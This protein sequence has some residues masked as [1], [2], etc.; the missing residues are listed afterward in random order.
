MNFIDYCESHQFPSGLSINYD[1]AVE[2]MY[3]FERDKISNQTELMLFQDKW[4]YLFEEIPAHP[5]DFDTFMWIKNSYEVQ[6][7]FTGDDAIL[8]YLN[9]IVPGALLGFT[10][11]AME[12]GVTTGLV[13]L[14][15]WNHGLY[16]ELSDGSWRMK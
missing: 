15:R 9:I 11:K 4:H 6:D 1:S 12:C 10:L 8:P 7:K 16:E 5:V 2:L 14:Q 13:I 3:A